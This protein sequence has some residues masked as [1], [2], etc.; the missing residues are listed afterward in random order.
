MKRR[1]LLPVAV[2]CLTFGCDSRSDPEKLQGQWHLREMYGEFHFGLA[3]AKA[4]GPFITFRED[5]FTVEYGFGDTSGRKV[6]GT[7]NCD[8][9][10]SPKQL[11]LNLNSRTV[12]AIYDLWSDT[13]RLCV[14]P[15]EKVPPTNFRVAWPWYKTSR[16][17]LL[18]FERSNEKLN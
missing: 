3:A 5:R 18:I 14:G 8:T 2:V 15:E 6:G 10:K 13:L 4:R 11:T 1:L 17:A 16:P 9:T 7:F 12:V